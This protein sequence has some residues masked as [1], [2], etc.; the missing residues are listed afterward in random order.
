MSDLQDVVVIVAKCAQSGQ[1]FGVRV[2]RVNT[3][4]WEATWSFPIREEVATREGYSDRTIEGCFALGSRFPGCPFCECCSFVLCDC[5][6]LS[7]WD[8]L[9]KTHHCPSCRKDRVVGGEVTSM[10]V[11]ADR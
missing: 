2:A 7:C 10:N 5:G 11:S 1:S 8:G 4:S 6:Q 9:S 3:S